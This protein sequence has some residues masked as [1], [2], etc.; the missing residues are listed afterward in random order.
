MIETLLQYLHTDSA[1]CR[2][3]PGPVTDRQAEVGTAVP[4]A[5]IVTCS[6]V[7]CGR[8][9]RVCT[10]SGEQRTASWHLTKQNPLPI[11]CARHVL[12]VFDPILRWAEGE[13]QAELVAGSN[14]LGMQQS[15]QLVSAASSYLQGGPC[16]CANESAV[17]LQM[18]RG[19]QDIPVVLNSS[20]IA[21][22]SVASERGSC[23][24]HALQGWTSGILQLW[25]LRRLH[26]DPSFSG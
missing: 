13:L 7:D 9:W 17:V 22:C 8:L 20:I 26:A 15:E 12:Q 6:A 4:Q 21:A 1:C 3:E 24:L 5:A 11:L 14:I 19:A 18:Q 23:L 2:E 10:E 16:M 25:R